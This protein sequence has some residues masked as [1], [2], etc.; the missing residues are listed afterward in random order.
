MFWR[1]RAGAQRA[2]RE[3]DWK[4]LRI[5]GNEFLFDLDKDPR[6]RGNL[7][8]RRKDVFER[9]KGDWE[10]WNSTMLPEHQRPVTY[11]NSSGV[12]ADRYGVHNPPLPEHGGPAKAGARD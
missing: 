5:A 4:Y 2:V 6:E 3:G 1:F 12:L 8:N 10:T 7:R 9:L 11:T